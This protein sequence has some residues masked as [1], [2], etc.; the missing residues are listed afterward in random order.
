MGDR[1]IQFL[2][3]ATV[4]VELAGHR[5]LT[6]PVLRHRVTFL[7]RVGG[8]R[9]AGE[10]GPVHVVVISHLHHDHADVPS[11]RR[12]DRATPMLVPVGSH[13]FFAGLGFTEVHEMPVG[14]TWQPGAA[15]DAGGLRITATP[16]VHHGRRTPF[17]PHAESIGFLFE[18]QSVAV[19]FA[20][21]TDIFPAMARIHHDL[22]V[23]LLP[24]WG[25]GPTLGTGHMDPL[26]AA[27]ALDLL[28]P[29][30][31]VP[32][33]W[34][35]LFPLGMRALGARVASVLDQPPRLF[36]AHAARVR[37]ECRVLHTEPGDVVRFPQ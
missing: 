34:G 10:H 32:I 30:Y 15:S 14:A 20:G 3:H 6:D 8:R 7:G 28:R 33:H 13:S 35:T 19:Y 25:W 17:G 5:I 11:L 26:R 18:A 23:A 2:G 27:E 1:R 29:R 21:D 24:V 31:A 4:L 36:A 37:P 12:L 22:D 16:A 9:A